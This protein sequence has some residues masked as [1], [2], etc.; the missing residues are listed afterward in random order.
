MIYYVCG[1]ICEFCF[2]SN[3]G[4]WQIAIHEQ[5]RHVASTLTRH[6]IATTCVAQIP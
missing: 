4:Y 2:D 5:L 1:V 3:A 6:D